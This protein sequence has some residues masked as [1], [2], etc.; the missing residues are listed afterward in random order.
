MLIIPFVLR[1]GYG[2][3]LPIP[4]MMGTVGA[5]EAVSCGI[6]GLLLYKALYAHRK[7]I[8]RQ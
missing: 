2:I 4:I 7:E 8:F 6:L 3:A 1:Y 5:G